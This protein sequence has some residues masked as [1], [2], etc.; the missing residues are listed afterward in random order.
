MVF[1]HQA[2]RWP[3]HFYITSHTTN[4]LVHL[5]WVN[6][7]GGAVAYDKERR[8][9]GRRS[10]FLTPAAG[11]AG[12]APGSVQTRVQEPSGQSC[13]RTLGHWCAPSQAR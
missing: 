7:S 2:G 9:L 8:P 12:D 3:H 4:M 1:E 13:S 5:V 11:G 10:L 6:G